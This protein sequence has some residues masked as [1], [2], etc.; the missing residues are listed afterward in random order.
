[1]QKHSKRIKLFEESIKSE[2]TKKVYST[3]LRVYF[4]YPGSGKFVDA[5]NAK[6]IEDHVIKFIV[7]MKKQ[8]KSFAAI[9]NYVSAICKYYRTK[10]V[11]LDS[12]YIRERLPEFKKSRKDRGYEH[13]EIQS[14]LE[15]A[16]DR[17]RAIILLLASTGMRIGAVPS[18]RM[19]NLEKIQIDNATFIYKILVYEGF[20]QE[21]VT[22]CTPECA[23][24][25]DNYLDM[26]K[27]YGEKISGNS[28]LIREQFNV[29]NPT[30]SKC[31]E[32]KG[33]TLIK[34]LIDF[35]ERA[36]IREKEVLTETKKRAEIRKAVPIAHGFRKFFTSQLVDAVP[37]V[38]PELRWLLEGHGLKA[39]DSHYVRT[40]DKQLLE[41]YE[42]GLDNLTIDP[43]NRLQ[44]KV[45]KLE[46]EKSQLEQIAADVAILKKKWKVK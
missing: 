4:D 2:Y 10:R 16:D 17:F 6:E 7:S 3:C 43:A 41:E 15:I 33:N 32:V 14:L 8:G 44:K 26:R 27:R 38:K 20:N 25:I 21:Y 45:K 23:K 24:A 46:I 11:S 5:T 40:S 42:K 22:Y 35:A 28:Y 39:N 29:R 34:K 12:K 31:R 30:A 19:R 18:L 37:N 1:M 9:H 36:G 13:K